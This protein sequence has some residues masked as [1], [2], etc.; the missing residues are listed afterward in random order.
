MNPDVLAKQRG[1][2]PEQPHPR[3]IVTEKSKP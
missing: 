2:M 3:N 1:A